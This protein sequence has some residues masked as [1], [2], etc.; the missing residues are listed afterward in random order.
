[1]ISG[2]INLYKPS[3]IS[4]NK[5]LGIV[6]AVLRNYGIEEKI[7]HFGT[8]DPLASGVLPLALG[9]AT[10][11]FDYSLDKIKEY[12][13]TFIFGAISDS[14]D[15]GTEVKYDSAVNVNINDVKAS[16]KDNIGEINQV[17]PMYSAKSVAG[18]R[19]YKIARMGGEIELKPKKIIIYDIVDVKEEG[20]NT[21]SMKIVCGGGTYVRAI[22]RDIAKS[23]G[24]TAVMSNL[25]RTKSGKF[26][27]ENAITLEFIKS[28]NFDIKDIIL[29]CDL[30]L[31]DF[32]RIVI[33]E[34]QKKKIL[35]GV[36]ISVEEANY[37]NCT[38][39]DMSENLLGI[40][41]IENGEMR[42][43]TWLI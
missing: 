37:V 11:L 28:Q 41:E 42:L 5:A 32:E 39:Y 8:L 15:L 24:T 13:A 36:K 3:G 10:R 17:P 27:I 21:F 20:R 29:P 43:K 12:H 23:L 34:K 16:I 22:G 35:N 18:V 33:S 40:G 7:G 6:K 14:L 38:V 1:M 19:A 4:S 30:V 9:R 2:F 26:D 31:N 25:I